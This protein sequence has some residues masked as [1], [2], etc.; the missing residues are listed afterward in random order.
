VNKIG[1]IGQIWFMLSI[2]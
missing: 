2:I 1:E